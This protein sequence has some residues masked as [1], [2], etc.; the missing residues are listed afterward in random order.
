MIIGGVIFVVKMKIVK[1]NLNRLKSLMRSI[2]MKRYPCKSRLS[3]KY[4]ERNAK[5]AYIV[6]IL[7]HNFRHA[8]YIDVAMPEGATQ[9][10]Q[11]Q[12]EWGIPS[13]LVT[14]IRK[15]YPQVSSAQIYNTWRALSETYWRRDEHQIPSAIKL[16]KEFSNEVDLFEPKDIP[17]GVEILA[18]GMKKI[19]E[20]LRGKIFQVAMDATCM[21][22]SLTEIFIFEIFL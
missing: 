13:T 10:I 22:A 2:A 1:R 17:E 15:S 11:N 20:P 4:R 16:L 19:A 12:A 6:I 5:N 7:H 14:Q 9:M 3:I 8:N 18:W 21:Y